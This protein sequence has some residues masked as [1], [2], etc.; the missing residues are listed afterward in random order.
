MV[1][2]AETMAQVSWGVGGQRASYPSQDAFTLTA[3]PA[4]IKYAKRSSPSLGSPL[5]ANTSA[6]VRQFLQPS[7]RGRPT[8]YGVASTSSSKPGQQNL[9]AFHHPAVQYPSLKSNNHCSLRTIMKATTADKNPTMVTI[10][11][12]T[13]LSILLRILPRKDVRFRR[14]N[15]RAESLIASCSQSTDEY[16]EYQTRI[17]FARTSGMALGSGP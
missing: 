2:S 3:I 6:H 7:D 4:Y 17:P 8:K 11:H 9:S 12:P 10:I 1:N 16:D 15:L 14:R 13:L 5:P